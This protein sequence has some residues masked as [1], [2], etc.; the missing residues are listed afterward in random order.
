MQKGSILVGVLLLS[1]LIALPVLGQQFT[2]TIREETISILANGIQQVSYNGT[3]LAT[4]EAGVSTD[5]FRLYNE[6]DFSIARSCSQSIFVIL[7]GINY[8]LIGND[9]FVFGQG[10]GA[11]GLSRFTWDV[12]CTNQ[13][14]TTFFNVQGNGFSSVRNATG[15]DT[16]FN[17]TNSSS[18]IWHTPQANRLHLFNTSQEINQTATVTGFGGT[19]SG[20][21]GDFAYMGQTGTSIVRVFNISTDP[22]TFILNIDLIS[23]YNFTCGDN[24][25]VLPEGNHTDSQKIAWLVCGNSENLIQ[26][27]LQTGFIEGVLT[28]IFP[29]QNDTITRDFVSLEVLVNSEE[30]G[31]VTFFLDNVSIGNESFLTAGV[32]TRVFHS[33]G[34]LTEG[35]HTWSAR[36]ITDTNATFNSGTNFFTVTTGLFQSF[37][38]AA[39]DF[40]GVSDEAG[41]NIFGLLVALVLATSVSIAI[42]GVTG[43]LSG[44]VVGTIFLAVFMVVTLV[45]GFASI[46]NPV[47]VVI[48]IVITAFILT[49]TFS[50]TF[51]G[52]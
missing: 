23:S 4:V 2:N 19:F 14:D 20:I 47:I 48:F 31:T 29:A 35:N 21:S 34:I 16:I 1:V 9:S 26:V 30:N 51:S 3:H 42:A 40:F 45:F 15:K 28:A 13:N 38:V 49:K 18:G 46:I 8:D 43:S 17:L 41:L 27:D 22:P 44:N 39:G 52:V 10:I 33:S 11:A 36:L 50:S 12:N 25:F 7:S 5:R 32:P 6:T 24:L 37:G